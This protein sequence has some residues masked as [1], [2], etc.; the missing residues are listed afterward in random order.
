[1]PGDSFRARFS[2]RNW[3]SPLDALSCR[4]VTYGGSRASKGGRPAAARPGTEDPPISTNYVYKPSSEG[5]AG[6][7]RRGRPWWILLLLLLVAGGA[8]AAWWRTPGARE[9]VLKTRIRK[10]VLLNAGHLAA[11]R[12]LFHEA[13]MK[14]LAQAHVDTTLITVEVASPDSSTDRWEVPLPPTEPPDRVARAVHRAVARFGGRIQRPGAGQ[15]AVRI[16]A[17]PVAGYTTEI[18]LR[19]RTVARGVPRLA[20]VFEQFGHREP[21]VAQQLLEMR[22]GFSMAILPYTTGARDL[23]RRCR[24]AGGEVLVNL[25]MEGRDYPRVDPGPGAILVDQDARTI[26]RHLDDAFDQV[27]GAR[28]ALTFLGALAVEDKDVMAAVMAGLSAR[29]AYFVDASPTAYSQA[30]QSAKTAGVAGLTLG[31]PLDGEGMSAE[32]IRQAL[33]TLAAAARRNGWAAARLRPY[34]ATLQAL[35][36]LVPAWHR[37]GIELVPLSEVVATPMR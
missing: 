13:L 19:A 14:E 24:D 27:E 15:E 10:A 11:V 6:P 9:L 30:R 26:R 8:F 36:A 33:E 28:G 17:H 29:G 16:V 12:P 20:L 32:Q 2:E 34:P 22:E 4:T 1:M 31:N 23:A 37:E 35:R 25:P 3:R 21:A 5:P 7:G 18:A